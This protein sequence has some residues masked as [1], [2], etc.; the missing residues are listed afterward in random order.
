MKAKQRKSINKKLVDRD[1][2][3]YHNHQMLLHDTH[4]SNKNTIDFKQRIKL[5]QKKEKDQL[6]LTERRKDE[7]EL[8]IM[9]IK[10]KMDK[11]AN[12]FKYHEDLAQQ[13]VLK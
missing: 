5:L 12:K 7:N 13:T 3:D 6:L 1:V 11:A 8:Q 10:Q 4:T 9:K 2:K